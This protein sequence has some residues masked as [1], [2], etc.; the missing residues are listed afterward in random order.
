MEILNVSYI[1]HYYLKVK[2][3]ENDCGPVDQLVH[4]YQVLL[5]FS[6]QEFVRVAE[7][8]N[9]PPWMRRAQQNHTCIKD[10]NMSSD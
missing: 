6:V 4:W 3:S 2:G 5:L 10:I 1:P 9:A 8:H 7:A